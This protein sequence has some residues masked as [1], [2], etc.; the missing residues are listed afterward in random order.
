M[1]PLQEEPLAVWLEIDKKSDLPFIRQVYEQI[2]GQILR[3]ELKAGEKLPSTRDLSQNLHLSRNVIL[4]AYDLLIAEGYIDSRLG[5]GSYVADGAFLEGDTR[6]SSTHPAPIT[7]HEETPDVIDFRSGVPALD[8]LPRKRWIQI[9]SQICND[10]LV[11]MFGYDYP[12]GRWEL[13]ETLCRFLKKSRGVECRPDQIVITSGAVQGLSI[14]TTILLSAQKTMIMED[15]VHRK[16]REIFG[17]ANPRIVPVPTDDFGIQTSLLPDGL[18]PALIFVTPSHQYP[19]G[20]N[21]PI[22]RRIDLIQYARS[23]ECFIIEDDYDSEFRYEGAPVSSLQGLDPDHVIY[24]GT[25]SKTLFPALRL[26]YMVLPWPLVEDCRRQKYLID[27]H[28]TTL[29]Q[30]TMARFIDEGHFE[31]HVARMKKI[32]RRRRDSLITALKESFGD[33]VAVNGQSTGLHLIARFQ[34]VNFNET[35]VNLLQTGGVAVYPVEEH[36]IVGGLNT[37]R[38]ILGYSHLE[39]EAI[40]EG[41]QRIR[42]TLSNTDYEK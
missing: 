24:V 18:C 39:S 7:R 5:S 35:L 6:R 27:N 23:S 3:G 12:E 34:G 1:V 33:Q 16:I 13:R 14:L 42:R 17:T 8:L 26:G 4:E 32:Y 2:R 29:N 37:D 15:P 9:E 38:I 11:D 10:A 36:A 25:F 30:L 41:V 20:G 21:L 31:R 22:T 19:T 40:L 28:S